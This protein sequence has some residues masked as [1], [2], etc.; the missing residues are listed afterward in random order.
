MNTGKHFHILFVDTDEG[1][2]R[3]LSL[4]FPEILPN[5][6]LLFDHALS[7]AVADMELI[8]FN[9]IVLGT[10]ARDQFGE[11]A[12]KCNT[13]GNRFP[14]LDL[15][16]FAAHDVPVPTVGKWTVVQKRGTEP[17]LDAIKQILERLL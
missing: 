11:I 8:G 14:E 1:L 2:H 15:I 3:A 5:V 17:L 12:A 10:N 4:A 13:L 7:T 6:G 16:L 9:A